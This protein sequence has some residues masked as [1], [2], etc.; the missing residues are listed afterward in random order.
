M[1]EASLPKIITLMGPTA[2]GKTALAIEL[3]K[4]HNCEI[5]SVDSALIYRGMD[6]GS[7]KPTA[8]ELAV[9]PHRLIDIRD[10]LQS[11]SAAD[12]RTDALREI[13]DI[14]KSGKTPLLVG[15]TML[16]FKALLEGLSPLPA[17]DEVI[18]AEIAAEAQTHG[19]Q[20]LHDE[21]TRVD[22]VSAE[23]IHPNDPQRLSRALE[24][25]RISGKSLTQ[26]T[27][28]KSPPLPYEVIQFAISPKDRKVLH[29]S[30]E[31]RFKL[32]LNQ[33]FVEEVRTL[34][35]RN[36]LHL[37]LPSMRCVG[38]RQCWQYLD[39][40]YDYNTM[41]DK[42]VIATRQLAK[43]QLTWLRG[44]SELNWL[45]TGL[46]SNLTSVLRHCR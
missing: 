15:G 22:S 12:F 10:P 9:A 28:I 40:D 45:E 18:R 13:A 16:Y 8:E 21:L 6:I 25:F 19:W 30:I 27:Q 7:A 46:D 1:S 31:E 39:G 23:R 4:E 29:L 2:S 36:D 17:A 11:Y 24:V 38:Y 35:Q 34:R 5:I 20:H 43:R 32:M 41:V 42:G 44:W 37:A 3:V 26:L 14:V 33:G